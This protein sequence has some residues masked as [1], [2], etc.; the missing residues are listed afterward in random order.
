M[1]MVFTEILA[2]IDRAAVNGQRL[3]LDIEHVRALATSPVYASI[4]EMK[5]KE[6]ADLWEN[7]PEQRERSRPASNSGISGSNPASKEASGSS[8]GTM[9]TL[10]HVAAERQASATAEKIARLSKHKRR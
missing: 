8:P 1:G 2:K 9:L 5:A 6:F 4:A 3:H 7:E 10:V